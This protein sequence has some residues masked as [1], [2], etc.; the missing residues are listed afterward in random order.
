M[1]LILKSRIRDLAGNL[2]EPV[3]F[4]ISCTTPPLL[5][6]RSILASGLSIAIPI[7]L[8]L[9]LGF[10]LLFYKSPAE[11]LPVLRSTL[12]LFCL[13]LLLTFLQRILH[14]GGHASY[15]V[16]RGVPFSI[17]VHP[18]TFPGYAR[19]VIDSS[20]WRDIPGSLT[21]L[22]LSLLI[23]L[24]FWKHRSLA[25][26]PLVMLFP[27]VAII[28]GINVLGLAGDFR[29][30]VQT[31]A[32]SPI[33]FYILGALIIVAGITF[34]FALLPLLALSPKDKR[35]LFVFPA[36]MFL[37]SLLSF[38]VACIV[39]PG[40]PIDLEYFLGQE[41]LTV[42]NALL[43]V[44]PVGWMILAVLYV[45]L[46][47]RAYPR[48]PAWLRTEAGP[49]AWKDLRLPALLATISVIMGWII[50]T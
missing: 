16:L 35:S 46:Y 10:W 32:L 13:L 26:L 23:S 2:S 5:N 50:I 18:F 7:T 9:L 48:L 11:R 19:P 12:L 43:L 28:D 15:L 45:T 33:P 20:I 31:N 24:P 37:L 14:E 41:I 1:E 30:L 36:A 39:V 21:A 17:Y 29:N 47:N 8:I 49:L 40:S 44:Q 22:L 27:Y 6:V 4:R 25:L 42:A 34:L 3:T 38:L